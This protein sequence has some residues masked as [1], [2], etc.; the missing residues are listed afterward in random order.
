MLNV[1][2]TPILIESTGSGFTNSYK[3]QI[4]TNSQG[5]PCPV[6]CY[7][8]RGHTNEK[9][10]YQLLNDT[11]G[12]VVSSSGY[13][14]KIN[15]VNNRIELWGR[16]NINEIKALSVPTNVYKI[17]EEVYKWREGRQCHFPPGHK[18]KTIVPELNDPCKIPTYI[19]HPWMYG[20]FALSGGGA[21]EKVGDIYV[22]K[23]WKLSMPHISQWNSYTQTYDIQHPIIFGEDKILIE[24]GT[25]EAFKTIG[26]GNILC[27][28][29]NDRLVTL[30]LSSKEHGDKRTQVGGMFRL[31]LITED[32][33]ENSND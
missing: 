18:G 27:K 5:N 24:D 2:N 4:H 29:V 12:F 14:N 1:S 3:H 23:L 28:T 17:A 26:A 20:A 32:K 15:A 10:V 19:H 11:K 25:I 8:Q 13:T 6:L 7:L 33:K 16:W 9:L 30:T 31:G 21:G 22:S